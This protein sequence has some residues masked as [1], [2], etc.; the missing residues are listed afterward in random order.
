MVI[1]SS[2]RDAQIEG[3]E[4]VS[5]TPRVDAATKAAIEHGTGDVWFVAMKLEREL[6]AANQI[7]RQQQ[8]LEEDNLRLTA[9]VAQLYQG[10]EEQKQRLQRLEEAGDKLAEHHLLVVTTYDKAK[11][12]VAMWTNAKDVQL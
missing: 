4:A 12:H 10:A 6:N 9:K 3:G 5:D 1:P 8:L 11:D 7:I 2:R